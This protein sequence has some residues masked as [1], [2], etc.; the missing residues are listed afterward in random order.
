MDM[1]DFIIFTDLM[2]EDV[3]SKQK[4]REATQADIDLL[5]A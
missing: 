3:P 2:T 5:L 1:P 4:V